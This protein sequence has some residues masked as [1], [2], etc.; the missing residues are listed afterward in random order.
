MSEDSFFALFASEIH[1]AAANAIRWQH[2]R[3][4]DNLNLRDLSPSSQ[5]LL[6]I[7]KAAWMR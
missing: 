6:N 2:V 3:P 5:L 1:C 4:S 7:L